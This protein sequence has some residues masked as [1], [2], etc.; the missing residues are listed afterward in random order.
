MLTKINLQPDPDLQ[1]TTLAEF[2]KLGLVLEVNPLMI[3]C[4]SRNIQNLNMVKKSRAS[5]SN[6][7]DCVLHVIAGKNVSCVMLKTQS[8][9]F[10]SRFKGADG[11]AL[12]TTVEEP[13]ITSVEG[14]YLEAGSPHVE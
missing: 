13:F 2:D 1:V 8:K 11:T 9:W 10:D 3:N 7:E 5:F 14:F 6:A 12:A 4:M